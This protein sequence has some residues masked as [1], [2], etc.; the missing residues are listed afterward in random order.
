MQHPI[1]IDIGGSGVRGAIIGGASHTEIMSAPLSDRS[2]ARV[3]Q[4]VA[5]LVEKL[6]STGPL[7]V[8]VPGFIQDGVVRE[9][10]NFPE[11]RDLQ[12]RD[13]IAARL[14]RPVTLINDANAAA[15]GAWTLRGEREDLVLLTLGT[16]VGGGVIVDGVP[17][18]G[19]GGTGAEL[20]HIFVGGDRL[21]GCGA[22]G[23][24]ETWC[25]TVGLRAAARER[26]IEVENGQD[27][28]RHADAG[29]AWALELLEQAGQALG[30]GLAS[31]V[32]IF[33]PD[34]VV[35][36]GGLSGAKKYL[37]SA[38]R[39]VLETQAIA[40]SLERLE[41]VWGGRAED[42]AV[43]GAARSAVSLGS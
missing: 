42:Y 15:L 28:L 6:D 34:V 27:V 17:L 9:S 22:R 38:A 1:G 36:V 7:G 43:H 16:G 4:A 39:S 26:G 20:G 37:D 2:S 30:R 33:N 12:L 8:A 10:P 32:N 11:W 23:C 24:L 35:L 13:Q 3:V 25:S 18:V 21:C 29:T 41:L 14:D 19:S 31:F 40:P 5:R